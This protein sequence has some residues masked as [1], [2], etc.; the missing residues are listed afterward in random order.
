M[1]DTPPGLATP[2][3]VPTG[4]TYDK[5]GS[6]NPL[7]KRLMSA[8]EREALELLDHARPASIVDV[9][10]GEGVLTER[11]AQRMNGGRVVGIDLDDPKLRAEWDRRA[12]PNLEFVAGAGDELPF[13]SDS[14]DAASAIEVLEHVPDPDAVLA[15]MT[16]VAYAL[17]L[18]ERSPRASVARTQHGAGRVHPRTS[19]IRPAT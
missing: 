8:F 6:T 5:Y 19:A 1:T 15:E 17:A 16:R 3:A 14:F 7:V 10:C 12:L 9:G 4:N 18:G 13:P 2:E 11:W